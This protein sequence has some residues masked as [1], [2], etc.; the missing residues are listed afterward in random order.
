MESFNT[1]LEHRKVLTTPFRVYTWLPIAINTVLSL[2]R[3]DGVPVVEAAAAQ[4]GV[5]FNDAACHVSPSNGRAAQ[6][7]TDRVVCVADTRSNWA[8][9]DAPG[10]A[11]YV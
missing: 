9:C 2:C 3:F 8:G 7:V 1:L 10:V 6:Y 4:M 5:S 11:G